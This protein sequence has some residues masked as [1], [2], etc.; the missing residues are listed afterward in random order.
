[1]DQAKHGTDYPHGRA[2][3]PHGFVEFD[4]LLEIFLL[5]LD[6]VLQHL[7]DLGLLVAIHHHLHP[8]FQEGILDVIDHPL[9]RQHAAAPGVACQGLQQLGL[10][11]HVEAQGRDE[12]LETLEGLADH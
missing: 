10:L 12:P 1:M 7:V 6:L 4:G 11:Q 5:E 3:A 2:V 8:F 9:Q